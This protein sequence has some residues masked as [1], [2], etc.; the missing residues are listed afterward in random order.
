MYVKIFGFWNEPKLIIAR[1]TKSCLWCKQIRCQH[2]FFFYIIIFKQ[3]ISNKVTWREPCAVV[4][5]W[6]RKLGKGRTTLLYIFF[7]TLNKNLPLEVFAPK[8]SFHLPT[9]IISR[10]RIYMQIHI[11]VYLTIIPIEYVNV[12]TRVVFI[13]GEFYFFIFNKNCIFI[14]F[15]FF[16]KMHENCIYNN[17]YDFL[18]I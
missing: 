3:E 12:Y 15:F 6:C 14:I 18:N 11:F 1:K 8:A 4:V 17:V 9:I 5:E 2:F 10:P 7:D 13:K 16:I